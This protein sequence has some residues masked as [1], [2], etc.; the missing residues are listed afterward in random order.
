MQQDRLIYSLLILHFLVW[1]RLDLA[2]D[3]E[4]QSCVERKSA[5]FQPIIAVIGMENLV[6]AVLL[7]E[8]C[9][10]CESRAYQRTGLRILGI[11]EMLEPHAAEHCLLPRPTL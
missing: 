9:G 1:E 10:R 6:S 8:W 3:A 5:G 7:A 4:K 2:Q 11:G